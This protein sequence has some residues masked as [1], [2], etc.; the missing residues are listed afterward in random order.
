MKNLK[1]VLTTALFATLVGCVNGD[2]YGTP[3]LSKDCVTI[4]KT[5]EVVDITS[6]SSAAAT[7]YTTDE[8]L[9]DYIEAY[10]TSSDEGGNF[11]KSISMMSLDGL[12]GFSMPVDN[13]NLYTEFE[14]GD[15]K[16]VV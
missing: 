1:L 12:Q 16:S 13:Y 11:Y 9:V 6:I 4:E 2:D 3:D 7:Q 5:K 15:R 14:P 10:V 8:T